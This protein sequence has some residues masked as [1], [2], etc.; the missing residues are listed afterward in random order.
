MH[1]ELGGLSTDLP[2]INSIK[3]P[4]RLLCNPTSGDLVS[5]NAG[6]G[7]TYARTRIKVAVFFIIIK[8]NGFRSR[9]NT[10]PIDPRS[11]LNVS[12]DKLV[13]RFT[14]SNLGNL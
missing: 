9:P 13:R 11:Y 1:R 12:G 2:A 5:L 8:A 7:S 6:I 3:Y 10:F 14:E 4:G